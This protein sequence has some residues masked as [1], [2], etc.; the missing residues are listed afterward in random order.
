MPKIAPGD[1]YEDCSYH[2]CLCVSVDDDG[3]GI[4]GISLVDGS[5]PRNCSVVHCGVRNLTLEEVVLWKHKGPHRLSEPWTP[6]PDRQWWWPRPLEGLNPGETLAH[7]FESSLLFLRNHARHLLGD[8]IVGWYATSGSFS[9]VMAVPSAQIHFE[10][11][12]S[13]CRAGV[14][15]EAIKEGRLWPT[16]KISLLLV[17][18]EIPI[19]FEGEQVRGCGYAG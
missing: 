13:L 7:L 17:G 19:V 8:P 6:L 2:P 11:K 3:D 10:V 1:Y 16:I 4:S 9:E 18:T 12:G 14:S 15:V 5:Y